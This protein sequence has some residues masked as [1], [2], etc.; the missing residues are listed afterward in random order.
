[1]KNFINEEF[2]IQTKD[3]NITA[4]YLP[5]GKVRVNKGSFV[6]N[7][8][9]NSLRQNVRD[10]R[11]YLINNGY[12]QNWA[13]AKDYTF[14]N[15]SIAL[16]ALYGRMVD[17]NIDFITLDNI[18]LGTYL[19]SNFQDSLIDQENNK[20]KAI[21]QLN[22]RSELP[23][24]Y[25]LSFEDYMHTKTGDPS[26]KIIH[27]RFTDSMNNEGYKLKIAENVRELTEQ[28]FGKDRD[29][30][31]GVDKIIDY[32][33]KVMSLR[34]NLVNGHTVK[35]AVSL[36]K[37]NKQ[38][39]AKIIKDIMCSSNHAKA[40]KDAAVFFGQR[41]PLLAYLFF[42]SD[43]HNFLPVAPDRFDLIFEQFGKDYINCPTL[44]GNGNWNTYMSF[45]QS[46][47]DIRDQLRERYPD[48]DVSLLDAHSVIWIIGEEAFLDFYKN[49]KTKKVIQAKEKD[50]EVCTKARI[51]QGQYRKEMISYWNGKCAVTGC[52]FTD[53]LF[54]SH[55]KPWKDSDAVECRDPF[56]GLLL[57]PNLDVL[58]DGGLISFADSGGIMISG[59]LSEDDQLKLG[60][61]KSLRIQNLD[62]RHLPYLKYHREKVFRK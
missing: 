32:F 6:R 15:P 35:T 37:E 52:A 56:N 61:S 20:D 1:M 36:A 55:A 53:I 19:N 30:D 23:E 54:A 21:T 18:E 17:G 43:R 39:A 26:C 25:L 12:V 51:G 41:F 42:V 5:S 45:I 28:F 50:K 46:V 8:E 59:L 2:R 4:F 47:R 22:Y 10:L 31:P 14:E 44:S 48:E 29:K 60:I 33:E 38:T 58:F 62:S 27:N 11:S 49:N 7:F 9:V 40:Y 24:S 57:I 13:L 34:S 16:S 3:G